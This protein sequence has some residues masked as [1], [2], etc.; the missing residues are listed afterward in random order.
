MLVAGVQQSDSV[1]HIF[2]LFSI[3]GYYLNQSSV[4]RHLGCFHVSALVNSTTVNIVVHVSFQI[5]VF[6]FSGYIPRN[7]IAGYMVG[8]FYF[9]K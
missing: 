4:D 5:R 2:R 6:T 9:F 8:L 3:I 7:G 1:I